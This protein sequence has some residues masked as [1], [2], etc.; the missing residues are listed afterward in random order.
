MAVIL[1][2]EVRI[3]AFVREYRLTRTETS[4]PG[5]SHKGEGSIMPTLAMRIIM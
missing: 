4:F 5:A 2:I 3:S 1:E